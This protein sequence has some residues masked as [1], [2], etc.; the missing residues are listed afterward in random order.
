MFEKRLEV[1]ERNPSASRRRWVRRGI[2]KQTLTTVNM[3]TGAQN[4]ETSDLTTNI[5]K[6]L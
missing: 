6:M 3:Y 5:V 4:S 1:C 2:H